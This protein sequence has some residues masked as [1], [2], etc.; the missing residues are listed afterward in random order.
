MLFFPACVVLMNF[1]FLNLFISAILENFYEM[2]YGGT[3]VGVTIKQTD[4]QHFKDA[5]ARHAGKLLF[6][7]SIFSSRISNFII[8]FMNKTDGQTQ[9]LSVRRLPRLLR[10]IPPPLGLSHLQDSEIPYI[11][12]VSSYHT[13]PCA[14]VM[15][16]S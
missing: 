10:A 3:N 16:S 15:I 13:I 8:Y 7:Y 6:T 2:E 11:K 1:F 4:I 12:Q 5:W 9:L 14:V